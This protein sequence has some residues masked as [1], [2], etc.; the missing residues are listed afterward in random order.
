MKNLL[1][2]KKFI[3]AC[4][5][6]LVLVSLIGAIIIYQ[7]KEEKQIT[8]SLKVTARLQEQSISLEPITSKIPTDTQT[9]QK[10]KITESTKSSKGLPPTIYY[11]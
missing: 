3:M 10:E 7:P 11:L 4:I 5:F 2:N 9:I 8:E 1:S 6:G